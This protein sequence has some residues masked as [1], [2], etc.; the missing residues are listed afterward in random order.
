MD[1]EDQNLLSNLLLLLLNSLWAKRMDW[2]FGVDM[3]VYHETG[4]N[5]RVPIVPDAFFEFG[6]GVEE[7]WR[8]SV[9]LLGVE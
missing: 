3:A 8:V 9:E 2:F 4:S 5:P 7:G 6:R 1:N